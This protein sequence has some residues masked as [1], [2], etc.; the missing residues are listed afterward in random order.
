MPDLST[1]PLELP[2]FEERDEITRADLVFYGVDHSGPS[3]TAH[4]FLERPN[5]TLTTPRT[6]EEGYVGSLTVFGHGGCYGDEGHCLPRSR[7]TDEFDRRPGHPLEPLTETLIATDA[8][9]PLLLDPTRLE[10]SVDLV[11]EAPGRRS[12]ASESPLRFELVRLLV[13]VA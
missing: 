7:Y 5:A 9:R 11:V 10:A 13:Y 2:T 4:V 8:L 1:A 12:P 6:T 3:Y